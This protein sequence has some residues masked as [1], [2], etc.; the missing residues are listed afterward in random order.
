MI[1]LAQEQIPGMGVEKKEEKEPEIIEDDSTEAAILEENEKVIQA[2]ITAENQQKVQ[3]E[4][5][6]KLEA[7]QAQKDAETA[8]Q[9]QQAS[10]FTIV[11]PITM[12]QL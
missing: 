1:E 8:A 10:S 5:Q 9:A 12:D 11:N 6:K 7:E 2:K 3:Q 4:E